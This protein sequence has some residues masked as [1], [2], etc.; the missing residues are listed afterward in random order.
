MSLSGRTLALVNF[1]DD[2]VMPQPR[3]CATY[4]E[5]VVSMSENVDEAGAPCA[6]KNS[7]GEGAASALSTLDDR[8]AHEGEACR[9]GGI[10]IM[11][12][13]PSLG[14]RAPPQRN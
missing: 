9:E 4:R 3:C 7:D 1:V 5:I 12:S 2:K 8:C 10:L 11:S 6:T 14:I 13:V